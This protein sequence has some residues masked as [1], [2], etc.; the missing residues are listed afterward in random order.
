MDD[1]QFT[2]GEGRTQVNLSANRFGGDI[3]VF[4]GNENAHIGAVAVGDYDQQEKRASTSVITRLG[5][6]DDAVA[7]N[8]AHLISRKMKRP[9]C[10]I[11]GIHL[12]DISEQEIQDILKNANTLVGNLLKYWERR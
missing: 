6:K 12:D 4:I 8:A 9:C 7:Q 2:E 5:H 1:C 11:A 10:V 3:V